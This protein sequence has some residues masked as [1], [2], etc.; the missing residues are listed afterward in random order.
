MDH[1]PLRSVFL[2]SNDFCSTQKSKYGKLD[3]SYN[4]SDATLILDNTIPDMMNKS[5]TINKT[6]D[7]NQDKVLME[8]KVPVKIKSLEREEYTTI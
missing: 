1:S 8:T 4:K 3:N 6:S 5:Y 7:I 2:C